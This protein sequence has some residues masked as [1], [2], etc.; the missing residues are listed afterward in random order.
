LKINI[1]LFGG[2]VKKWI[3]IIPAIWVTIFM[4]SGLYSATGDIIKKFPTPGS[5]PTGLAFDGKSFWMADRKSDS[6]Y[7]INPENGAI[8]NAVNAPGY[9]I[10]GLACENNYIWALDI[11]EKSILKF[12]PQTQVNEKTLP[13]PCDDPQGLAWD[14]TYLWIGD[15]TKDRLYQFSTEDG[16]TIREIPSPSGNPSGL[17]WDGKYLWVSDRFDDMVYMVLPENGNVILSI[18]TPCKYPRGIAHDGVFLWNVDY[19]SDTLYQIMLQDTVKYIQTNERQEKLEYIHQFRNYGPG[20]IT[21]LDIYIA[22]PQT[23]PYQTI[24]GVPIMTPS[25]TDYLNDKWGQKVAHYH[26]ASLPAGGQISVSMN[27]SAE[28][29]KLRYFIFPDKVGTLKDI[30]KEITSSYL[31][32]DT[33]YWINDPIIK[34]AAQSAIGNETNCYWIARKLFNYIIEKLY[35]ERVGGWNVAPTVL[36]RGNGSCSEYS[37]VYIALCRA[38][39][40]PARYAGAVTIRG[41]DAS[42]D[43]VFHRWVE[44]Y[45]PNYGWVPIDPSGGDNSSPAGQAAYFGHIN[46]NYLITT[47]GGGSSEYLEWGYNSNEIW[48]SKGKCKV[49]TEHIGEW[50]P[51][52]NSKT[53]SLLLEDSAKNCKPK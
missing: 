48:Q 31:V 14:G 42:T 8:I 44:V 50:S 25:P 22:I 47:L 40:L 18:P 52:S 32:D 49:Y 35:Y 21:S 27:A 24:I 29:Y 10:E 38:A 33:K 45:L 34:E 6:L 51:L 28:I 17:S 3:Y 16:T 7:Q 36:K 11:E 9:Q 39:G 30:P 37:F 13:G 12:N 1:D 46:N 41:D 26:Y 20:E 43:D 23:L 4:A 19:Q 2:I 53:D 15:M 5:C